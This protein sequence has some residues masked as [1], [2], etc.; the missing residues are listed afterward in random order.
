MLLALALVAFGAL[1]LTAALA[2]P[3]VIQPPQL[4]PITIVATAPIAFIV[5]DESATRPAE[6]LAMNSYRPGR[7]LEKGPLATSGQ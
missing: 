1:E 3:P 5:G 2:V 6:L 7:V 4:K